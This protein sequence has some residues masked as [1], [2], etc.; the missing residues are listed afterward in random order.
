MA[1][2]V[3]DIGV[4]SGHVIYSEDVMGETDEHINLQCVAYINTISI[5]I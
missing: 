2:T 4:Y 3:P 1:K 5:K